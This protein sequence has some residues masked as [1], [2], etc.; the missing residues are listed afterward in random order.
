[1]SASEDES[2]APLMESTDAGPSEANDP[3]STPAATE[4]SAPEPTAPAAAHAAEDQQPD[5]A[6]QMSEAEDSDAGPSEAND[7]PS[8]PAA[9]EPSA[10]EPTAPAAA[11]AA[12]D[13]Q[14]D[15]APQ[16]SE[17]EDPQPQNQDGQ[18]PPPPGVAPMP[19]PPPP[20]PSSGGSGGDSPSGGNSMHALLLC[21]ACF[22]II[23]LV[24]GLVAG[25]YYL[26]RREPTITAYRIMYTE[27]DRSG[28]GPLP[29]GPI[30]PIPD[31]RPTGSDIPSPTKDG[32]PLPTVPTRDRC[33]FSKSSYRRRVSSIPASVANLTADCRRCFKDAAFAAA[34]PEICD[35]W[36]VAPDAKDVDGDPWMVLSRRNYGRDATTISLSSLP[37]SSSSATS[38]CIFGS[39][40]ATKAEF[41]AG[42]GCDDEVFLGLDKLA[43]TTDPNGDNRHMFEMRV[44]I[45]DVAEN[46]RRNRRNTPSSITIERSE[47][48]IDSAHGI[49]YEVPKNWVS[50]EGWP[51]LAASAKGDAFCGVDGGTRGSGGGGCNAAIKGAY[52]MNAL[53]GNVTLCAACCDG[54]LF[55]DA[56]KGGNEIVE[57]LFRKT[58]CLDGNDETKK[59]FYQM[60]MPPVLECFANGAHRRASLTTPMGKAIVKGGTKKH[61]FWCS[62]SGGM[63]ILERNPSMDVAAISIAS[64]ITSSKS[65]S[66]SSECLFDATK[67]DWTTSKYKQ[68]FGC[69]HQFFIGTENAESL[70]EMRMAFRSSGSMKKGVL[71]LTIQYDDD[72]T[73]EEEG[74][75]KTL[76]GL[77]LALVAKLHPADSVLSGYMEAVIARFCAKPDVTECANVKSRWWMARVENTTTRINEFVDNVCFTSCDPKK[78]IKNDPWDKRDIKSVQLFIDND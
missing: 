41:A 44:V 38:D 49:F 64:N 55:G 74:D 8:T 72:K 3:P 37:A 21:C 18:P 68:G 66:S 56:L 32:R 27:L 35:V 65:S 17:A 1:M 52:W 4:P 12:E 58:R 15:V 33:P 57:V 62:A 71:K 54:K 28:D 13:Q 45:K 61:P 34:T 78:L 63:K 6:P 50:S 59:L 42:F 10:P 75:I 9:T 16:M 24:F 40:A 2:A 19:P 77:N 31:T 53:S 29:I 60:K 23:A 36:C 20:G 43:L 30:G 67:E 69:G 46:R 73:Y 7:P 11:P 39:A 70:S 25:V 47:F 14:P 5:V 48:F 76:N 51:Y 22:L 26:T